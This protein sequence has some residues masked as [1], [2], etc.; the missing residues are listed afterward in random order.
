MFDRNLRECLTF[1]DVMLVPAYSEVLPAEADVRSRLTRTI[2]LNIPIVSAAMD[3]VTEARSAVTMAR[4]GGIGIIH[5]N[6]G[7]AEQAHEVDRVKRAESGI[8]V[9]PVTVRPSQSL[10]EALGVMRS[11]EVSGV[12]VVEG[13]TAVGILTSRDIRFEKNLDQPVSAL[14]TTELVTVSPGCKP[15]EARQL[16]H[17][18]RIEKLLVVEDGKLVGLITIK[19]LLQAERNPLA[20]KDERGRLRV[21]AALG[22]GSDRIQRAEAL[23]EVGVDVL[24]IDTAHGHHKGVVDAV[25]D[26]KKR[27][28]NVQVVG[29]NIAT[30]EAA[31]ALIDAGADAIKV[32]IGPGS[33]CTTRIVAGIGVP[34]I[35]AIADC[36]EVAD[37]HGVPV[38]ADGGIKYSGEVTKALAAGAS[39]VMIG[40][41]FAGTDEA[42]G[43]LVLFQGRSYKVYR[44]MGSLGAMKKGSRDRYGQGGTADEK[45]VPEGIE[46]RVPHR[47]SLASILAQLVGGLRAGMGYTGS[48]TIADLRKDA[49]FI[50]ISSAGLRESHV[51]DVIITEEAPNYRV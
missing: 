28:P 48:R 16:L 39:C 41:L 5:K 26:T 1:D 29:G 19:D 44:G 8:I 46:G 37:R 51:H 13:T 36:V 27:Y 24:V 38:I 34:Q 22:P 35:T 2:E 11:N 6:L 49:K 42:P 17:K 20:N 4:Q 18:H 7:I 45:L 47:G 10:R 12:P 30:A 32:G 50:R 9:N 33:I 14:M 25:R 43:E 40:S 21:G 23:L 15:D 31:Q 3:S